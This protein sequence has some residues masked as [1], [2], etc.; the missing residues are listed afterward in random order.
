M[1]KFL[2][3]SR[4]THVPVLGRAVQTQPRSCRPTVVA[5]Q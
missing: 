3:W 5:A 4:T 1:T 2:P